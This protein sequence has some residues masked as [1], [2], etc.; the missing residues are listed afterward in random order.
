MNLAGYCRRILAVFLSISI[1][2]STTACSKKDENKEPLDPNPQVIVENTEVENIETE[3]VLAEHI[4]SEIYLEEFILAENK[5]TELLLEEETIEEVLFCQTIYVSEEN[6]D[7]FSE[8][9]QISQIFGD[10][11]GIKTL[12]KKV[13]IGTGVIVTVV[14]VKKAG[15]PQPIAN[16]VVAAADDAL[17]FA[18]DGA[19]IG[20]VFGAFTGAADEIDKAGRISAVTGFAL[21]TAGL[22]CASVSLVAAVP[23]AGTTSFG[24]AEGIHLAWA[25]VKI[26]LAS[27]GTVYTARETIKAFTSTN[28]SEIDWGNVNW[29]KLGV[30]AAQKAIKN[31]ADGYMWGSLYG[32][33][34]GTVEG[35]YQMYCTPYT[36]YQDRI[37][38]TPNKGG[39]WTGE[40]GE[41]DFV[42]D[43]P[44]ELADGT[45]ITKVSYKNGVPDFSK[46]QLAKVKISN[47]TEKRTPKGGNYEQADTALAEE[48][49]K[50]RYNNRR[51][52][53]R[54]VE[55]FR[56]DNGWTWH[57]MSNMEYMQLIPYE[58]NDVFLHYGGVAEYNAMIGQKGATDFD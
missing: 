3:T 55:K 58:V 45:I 14:I 2:F 1:V 17:K 10:E 6:I 36:K 32:L 53:A 15:V 9:S 13:A 51:W 11:K 35:Y 33:I 54:D 48:W 26:I 44:I 40:R 5:I 38:H 23:T 12:L 21:A 30:T 39:K 47:M 42:L 50:I 46:W 37:K 31:G 43:E 29:D 16:I 25:G 22:I 7:E 41:S 57:E 49:T 56:N 20:T 4:T 52:T 27:T 24:I 28:V 18:K 19:I 8:H 34:N